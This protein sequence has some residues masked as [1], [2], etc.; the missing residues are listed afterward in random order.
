MVGDVALEELKASFDSEL[1][2]IRKYIAWQAIQIDPFNASTSPAMRQ[3]I[4]D[5][6]RGLRDS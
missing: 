1:D 6:R 5:L 4:S 3:P 2:K